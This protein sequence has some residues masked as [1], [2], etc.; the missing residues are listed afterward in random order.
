MSHNDDWNKPAPMGDA[1]PA[2]KDE[3]E[4]DGDMGAEET[5]DGEGGDA[6]ASDDDT[7][8]EGDEAEGGDTA[9]M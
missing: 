9:A 3:E 2:G 7:D 5:P 8:K 1:M 4:K 6:A